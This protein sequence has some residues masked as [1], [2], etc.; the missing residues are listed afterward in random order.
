MIVEV[1]EV[2]FEILRGLVDC[3]SYAIVVVDR[4]DAVKM[5]YILLR[6]YLRQVRRC[7][8]R[9]LEVPPEDEFATD[10]RAVGAG[11]AQADIPCPARIHAEY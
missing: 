11:D 8:W 5:E 10:S 1:W 7:V 3:A 2:E 6:P 4:E 9:V